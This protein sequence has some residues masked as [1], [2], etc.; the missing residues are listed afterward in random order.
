MAE[1]EN[2]FVGF[3]SEVERAVLGD[4]LLCFCL[5]NANH[6]LGRKTQ[7][8]RVAPAHYMASWVDLPNSVSHLRYVPEMIVAILANQEGEYV[9]HNHGQD[10]MWFPVGRGYEN[11]I[12]LRAFHQGV[13]QSGAPG[14][15][16]DHT[17]DQFKEETDVGLD[18]LLMIR[19]AQQ[20]GAA[21]DKVR[22][23]E[24]DRISNQRPI[25]EKAAKTFSEDIRRFVRSYAS[26]IPRYAFVELLE[27]CIAVG[28]TTI[29]TS[30]IEILFEWVETGEIRK[31]SGQEPARLFV[32][33]SNGA[34]RHLKT[35]A[36]QSFDDF[37][38][39]IERFPVILMA[40]RLLDYSARY[41]RK[42]RGLA[43]Q[44]WPY[45]TDWLNLL[46]ELLHERRDEAQL[47]LHGIDRKA[48]ELTEKLEQDYPEAAE[49]LRN[50]S[51]PSPVWRLAES[52]TSLQPRSSSQANVIKMLDSTLLS[53]RPNGLAVKRTTTRN[54]VGTGTRKR[55]EVRSLVYA[56]SVLDYL[57]HL[58]IL[59]SGNSPGVRPLSLKEFIY[60]LRERYG[61]CI[62]VAPPGMTISNDLLQANRSILERRL[63]DL[64]LLVGVND[65]EAM[66]RLQPRFALTEED[67]YG[68]D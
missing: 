10:R 68:M 66:K 59:R 33:C 24:G 2:K 60:R 55:R 42:I 14:S 49:M 28:M 20:L 35:L 12:L 25:A 32:D 5:E 67:K 46:G 65:A 23:D 16:S 62:D 17:S 9:Q 50:K 41:D 61:L 34:D 4:L 7:V 56:D 38:R 15:L 22:G 6:A 30:T 53:D 26:V 36:E 43:I 3:R 21:P 54:I 44:T 45:A 37:M 57:V 19:L 64:G 47:I 39:R 58:H 18:Q 27:S 63:R 51:Q 13:T 31:S 11:N 52:L 48:E 8:Q 40:L 29:L 1:N